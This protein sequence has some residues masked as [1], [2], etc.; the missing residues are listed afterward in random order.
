MARGGVGGGRGN[1]YSKYFYRS[2]A[3]IEDRWLIEGW[4]LSEEIRC[5]I[6]L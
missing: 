2:G 4:P 5:V 3:I 6:V 1:Y